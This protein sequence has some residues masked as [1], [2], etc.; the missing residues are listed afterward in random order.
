LLEGCGRALPPNSSVSNWSWASCHE[1]AG[2]KLDACSEL[3][4][5]RIASTVHGSEAV[6]VVD[7][8]VRFQERVRDSSV[9]AREVNRVV[10][11]A[12]LRVVERIEGIQP[13]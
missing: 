11:S 9:D 3:Q 13:E 8:A 12:E 1:S 5:T 6:D 10:Q 7:G 2:L 4:D